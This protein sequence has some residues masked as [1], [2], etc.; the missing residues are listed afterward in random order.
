M[1]SNDIAWNTIFAEL[2]ILRTLGKVPFI[3]IS[4][5]S[6]NQIG[7]REA[8]LMAK[9]DTIGSL[10]KVFKENELNINAVS[11]GNYIIFKDPGYRSFISLPDYS[12]IVPNKISAHLDF[13]L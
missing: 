11:N 9:F 5:K 13:D 8:R 6:I 4:A 1:T 2:K 7:G 12:L 3:N 10:P